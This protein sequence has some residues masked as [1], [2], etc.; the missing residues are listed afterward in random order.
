MAAFLGIISQLNLVTKQVHTQRKPTDLNGYILGHRVERSAKSTSVKAALTGSAYAVEAK[1]NERRAA[2]GRCTLANTSNRSG[3]S[4]PYPLQFLCSWALDR[5]YA[6]L[7]DGRAGLSWKNDTE[8]RIRG[9]RSRG[10]S[11]CSRVPAADIDAAART[12]LRARG[13][14]PQFTHSTGHGVGFSAIDGNAP[15][16]TRFRR[17]WFLTSSR[18]FTSRMLAVSGI[19]TWWRSQ[20]PVRSC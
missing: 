18:L 7:F 15:P 17:K 2:Q 1:D 13:F 14:G 6:H 12:E 4:G 10:G 5:H 11:S 19:A 3:R 8:S 9:A 20:T 16:Q